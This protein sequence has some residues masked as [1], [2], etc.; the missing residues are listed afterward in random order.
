MDPVFIGLIGL[1]VLFVLLLVIGIPVATSMALVGFAGFWYLRGFEAAMI[2]LAVVPFDTVTNYSL[3][4][5][6]LFMFMANVVTL[7]GFGESLFSMAFKWLGRLPGG[8]LSAAA[9]SSLQSIPPAW[10]A[11][12]SWG[13]WPTRR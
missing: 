8:R 2:K 10:P 1:G 5:L 3:V 6:P 7:A 12:P 4:T 13:R 9:R 11:S